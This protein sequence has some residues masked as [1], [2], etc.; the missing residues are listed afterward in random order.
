MKKVFITLIACVLVLFATSLFTNAIAD[1][2]TDANQAA[3]DLFTKFYNDGS[4]KKD[5][6][7]YINEESV[8]EVK[9]YFHSNITLLERTTYYNGTELWMSNGNGYSGYG[10]NGNNLTSFKVSRSRVKGTESTLSIEGGMEGY[11]CTLD[12]F[13]KGTHES[14]HVDSAITLN[15]GWDI[16]NGV[17][18]STS[19]DILQ[20]YRLFTAPL[21]LYNEESQNYVDFSLAT[22]EEEV[23]EEK[24]TKNSS[25][26]VMKLWTSELDSAKFDETETFVIGEGEGSETYHLFSKA[27]VYADYITD[28]EGNG[29]E[30]DP[31]LINDETDWA[32]LGNAAVDGYKFNGEHVKLNANITVTEPIFKVS[33]HAFRG[34]L[35][36]NNKT[37]T[38]N[39]TGADHIAVIGY[40]G[41]KVSDNSIPTVKNLIVNGEISGTDKMAG[42]VA[43]HYGV[44]ENCTNNAKVTSTGNE[45][46]GL[47][48]YLCIGAQILNSK[49]TGDIAGLT[50]VGGAAGFAGGNSVVSGCINDGYITGNTTLG[51]IVGIASETRLIT[52]CVN[53][54]EVVGKSGKTG[55]GIAGIVGVTES[56][57][58]Q[59]TNCVNNGAIT[60]EGENYNAAGIVAV[61]GDITTGK[62]ILVD[63]CTNTANITA[64]RFVAG[65]VAN[66]YDGVITNC[67]N[68]GDIHGTT[69]NGNEFYL[70]GICAR[71]YSSHKITKEFNIRIY[72]SI[73]EY[74]EYKKELTGT[75]VNCSNSGKVYGNPEYT[76]HYLIGGIVGSLNSD[77]ES[78]LSTGIVI[79]C[80]NTGEVI[81]S[82]K[83]GGIAGFAAKATPA[84]S[85]KYCYQLGAT[86]KNLSGV[87]QT[88]RYSSGDSGVCLYI[89]K[90]GT[91][92]L[93]QIAAYLL[94]GASAKPTEQ[95]LLDGY[96]AYY[97]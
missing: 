33:D 85:M 82:G 32:T 88:G 37:I 49:N 65:I 3:L 76:K 29:T 66:N 8:S 31:Y 53:N 45:V 58:I 5:T 40:T 67:T 48:G 60:F 38:A 63:N 74:D 17:L 83:T 51:G 43:T 22:L 47:V 77:S 23:L 96:C 61:I 93:A 55:T 95:Q 41:R 34:T 90:T 94:S 42:I 59:I 44:M 69:P 72:K 81:G 11:Y 54:G 62:Y 9:E 78:T 89:G 24:N 86:I 2:N 46:G 25:R 28:L 91:S 70:G 30:R 57:N 80:Y 20:G 16:V 21:W 50:K 13:V 6:K 7:I 4:Y 19:K 52:K 39:I 14:A 84:Q 56:Q 92:T 18:V 1:E 27:Y 35:D 64:A 87:V 26:L 73:S 97:A 36:G 15:Q 10:T 71:S 79:A 12:D 75:I 68:S